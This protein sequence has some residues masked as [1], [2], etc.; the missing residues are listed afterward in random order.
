[1]N[2]SESYRSALVV[3]VL[4]GYYMTINQEHIIK[5]ELDKIISQY[6]KEPVEGDYKIMLKEII[7]LFQDNKELL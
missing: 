4:K 5:S 1:M 2:L 3:C 6:V 7:G